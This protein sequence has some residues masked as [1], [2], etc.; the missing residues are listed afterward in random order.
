[1]SNPLRTL[2]PCRTL[3]AFDAWDRPSDPDSQQP[4][5][6]VCAGKARS[7]S[8]NPRTIPRRFPSD[9]HPLKLVEALSDWI[10]R[11]DQVHR[12]DED[13]R[14]RWLRAPD[15]NQAQLLLHDT[16][17]LRATQLTPALRLPRMSLSRLGARTGG[18]RH[19]RA[20]MLAIL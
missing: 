20:F 5:S 18:D 13:V 9:S 10:H 16:Q 3:Q 14:F 4:G 11:L 7:D 6:S 19:R 2:R 17:V 1:V 12:E 15:L 8:H